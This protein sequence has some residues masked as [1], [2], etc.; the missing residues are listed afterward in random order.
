MKHYIHT[1]FKIFILCGVFILPINKGFS[2]GSSKKSTFSNPWKIV[3]FERKAFIENKGQFDKLIPEDK[4]GFSYCIDKGQ[5]VFFYKNKL[6]YHF[7]SIT[8]SKAPLLGLFE[9]EKHREERI[10][11][12]KKR[13]QY[14]DIEWLNSNPNATIV[15]ENKQSTQYP[16]ALIN[17]TEP[18]QTIYCDGYSKITY[19]N[20]YPNI[21][22]EYVFHPDNG[23]KY[24]LLL[25]PGA[26]ISQVKMKYNN[27]VKLS[28]KNGNIHIKTIVG[29]I[30]DHAPIT[31]YAENNENVP[32]AF[33]LENNTV[34]FD[35]QHITPN[36]E[37][38][39]D[40]WTLVPG[41]APPKA[42]DNGVDAN[43]NIYI[44]GGGGGTWVTE[45]YAPTGGAPIW[46]MPNLL[47]ASQYSNMYYGD[48]LVDGSGDFY[49]CQSV[50][51]D[52]GAHVQK[53]SPAGAP[54]W[55]SAASPTA[56]LEYWRMAL[57]C[58]TGKVI[59][60]GGGINY[61]VN[62]AQIDATTGAL[63]NV[64]ALQAPN[65]ISGLCV[66]E[67]GNSYTH[68]AMPN[69]VS[70]NDANNNP[71]ATASSGYSQSEA[72][73]PYVGSNGYNMMALGGTDFLFT[74]D[75]AT[76]IKWDKNTH[77]MIS[78][79]IIPGGQANLGSG[80]LADKANNMFVGATNGVYR[81][82]FNLVQ[83]EYQ[84]TTTAV[85]DIAFASNGDIVAC[86]D[87][88]LQTLPFGRE[89]FGSTTIQI[90]TDPC[91]AEINTVKVTPTQG[92]PPFTFLWDDGNTD[93]LR[94]NLSLGD[95]IVSIK[96]GSCTPS[97]IIDTVTIGGN[98]NFLSI[99]KT[100]PLCTYSSD[101]IINISLLSNQDI[102]G[103][104]WT[105]TVTNS[106]LNDSTSQ[107]TGLP[108]GTYNCFITS[109]LGCSFDTTVTL[110]SQFANPSSSFFDA[111]A[112][113]NQ[114]ILFD[115]N[116]SSNVG[117]INSWNWNFGDNTATSNSQNPS[118]TYTTAGT[119][120]TTLIIGTTN[121][122]FDTV[123][124]QTIIHPIPTPD[125]YADDICQGSIAYFIEAS[126]IQT[127]SIIQY[128]QWDFGDN[129]SFK[130]NQNTTH[131][132]QNTGTYNVELTA[133]SNFGCKDSITK[134]ITVNP[135]PTVTFT[136]SDTIN[137]SPLCVNFQSTVAL[138]GGTIAT[139][140]WNY[141]D[142]GAFDNTE[143]GSHCYNNATGNTTTPQPLLFDV[144]ITVT[145]DNGC[146]DIAQKPSYITVLPNP[147]ANFTATPQKE[148]IISPA[149][150]II[151]LSMGPITWLWNFGDDSTST[152]PTPGEYNY[153]DT[154]T[155]VIGL[156]ILNQYGCADSTYRTVIIEPDWAFFVP[157]A[158]SPNG[159]GIND[160]F[161]G[162]GYGVL[163]YQMFIFDRWG[164]R[165]FDTDSM[166][167]PWTGKANL[168]ASIAQMDVYVY[169]INIKDSLKK[170][171]E[172][173]GTVTL[174]R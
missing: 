166:Q 51:N 95:H 119:F 83:K 94:T 61:N 112:C 170:K 9:N 47:T 58:I 108:S 82:D 33:K 31:F 153:T 15:A 165:V 63:S 16:Y 28:V 81:F 36:K 24:N 92:V 68:G 98:T 141:G 75:G 138:S 87:G 91:D 115:E 151:D 11:D 3:P 71:I 174:V 12:A 17:V 136:A 7:N 18:T 21:D 128:W 126:N 66:D 2:Q 20:L 109:S 105:P 48:M 72:A 27:N 10:H 154:G 135:N 4:T 150:E 139:Y 39:I 127:P 5:Q 90:T 102:T 8:I 142:Q 173:T 93:S 67:S 120:T 113:Q 161:G 144:S 117:A 129:T 148:S 57:N 32:S 152:T 168:G 45:K 159:D 43:G 156:N 89:P 147:V 101:G 97:F 53:F 29:E 84:S 6:S 149:I 79:A 114:P 118:H 74:S 52:N 137:C 60:A 49:L 62:I 44:Y 80:I 25:H 1:L 157:N 73:N 19:K 167:K 103:I 110:V 162:N 14:I 145:T 78:S 69:S 107:A 35:I 40:P 56:M 30:I 85:Y 169:K 13:T 50:D 23:I 100:N 64:Q 131:L 42:F 122:C 134:P 22:V 124:K 158:F 125:F 34:S 104:V 76:V 132:F 54:I 55:T 155:Y 143:N 171:H 140:L 123:Q 88:F 26:D 46:S 106:L 121:G 86:G 59:V 96:D 37:V 133:T 38:V 164:N 41:F 130:N 99:N 160:T 172:Y 111:Q 146:M 163:E 70:F 77:A 65:D 116:S